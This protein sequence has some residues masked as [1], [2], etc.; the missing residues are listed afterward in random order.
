MRYKKYGV[1]ACSFPFCYNLK[2]IK[3]RTISK[4]L[5]CI[6][7]NKNLCHAVSTSYYRFINYRSSFYLNLGHNF[8]VFKMAEKTRFQRF[9]T[10]AQCTRTIPIRLKISFQLMQP[11]C[12]TPK[13]KNNVLN[14]KTSL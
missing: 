6:I 13:S 11:I 12:Y 9:F 4:S 14:F 10:F 2:I 7:L 8:Y 5:R 3:S 1:W